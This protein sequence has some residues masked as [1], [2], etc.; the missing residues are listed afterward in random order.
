MHPS[1]LDEDELLRQCKITT[2]RAGG[3]G[4]QNRNKVETLVRITHTTTGEQAHAGERRSQ[5][6]NKH[7]AIKR[8]RLLL[9]WRVRHESPAPPKPRGK[10]V[11]EFIES[12][13]SAMGSIG[14]PSETCSE[15][16]R[17]RVSRGKIA[18][19]PDHNDYPALLAEALDVVAS[20]AWEPRPAAE[21]LG[22]TPTQ[23]IR[24]VKDCPEA[25]QEWNR[26]RAQRGGHA[27]K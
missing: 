23:L 7:I 18:C 6:E 16:W 14:A 25:M 24:F 10:D 27:L 15:L 2:G 3:P 9:A 8:L 19:N 20:H 1:R 11:L 17:S 4:G 21:R 26:Q 5:A 12:L 13:D 22:I